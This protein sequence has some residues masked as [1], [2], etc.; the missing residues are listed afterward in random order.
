MSPE[1]C[2]NLL[3]SSYEQYLS[4][5]FQ[6]ERQEEPSLGYDFDFILANRKWRLLGEEMIA[7]ELRELTNLMNRWRSVLERWRIWNTVIS[8]HDEESAWLLRWEFVESLAHECLLR[9]SSLRDT[10]VSVATNALHQIRLSS[11][12]TYRDF[13][14]GDPRNPTEKPAHL[15]RAQKETRLFDLASKWSESAPFFA[16]LRCLNDAA[17]RERTRDYRNLTSHT[18][19]PRLGAGETRTVTRHVHQA[20]EL[21]EC[22]DG[23]FRFS[24]IPG[25]MAVGYGFGGTAPLDLT[26]SH[27]V[28]KQ[29]FLLARECYEKYLNLLS[30][31]AKDIQPAA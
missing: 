14:K 19:G 4:L 28:N 26:E 9:P 15:K 1:E 22:P 27:E 5:S 23:R 29:Q 13:L 16:A 3:S 6:R 25:K 30:V 12:K 18:I 24:P 17:Y 7:C 21:K 10:F 2:R 31:A 11:D 8:S 20:D